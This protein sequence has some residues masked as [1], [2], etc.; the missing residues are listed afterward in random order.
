MPGSITLRPAAAESGF[1]LIEVLVV[2][3][4]LALLIA[5]LLPSLQ[6]ARD[7]ARAAVCGANMKQAV[8]GTAMTLLETGMRKERW[9]TNFG[10]ATRSLKVNAQQAG[11]FA[12]PSDPD[13]KPIPAV[14]AKLYGGDSYRG[15]T[16]SDA[17]FNHVFRLD[18]G[19]WQTDIQDSVDGDMF[20]GDA[21][22][23][24]DLLLEYNA[25]VRMQTSADVRI[26]EKEA[27]WRFDVLTYKE[28]TLWPDAQPG[29]GPVSLPL[30]WMSYGVNASAGMKN[31]SGY[32]ALIVESGK[33]GVFPENLTKRGYST[34]TYPAD[35][36]GRVLRFR[37]GPRSGVKVLTGYDYNRK[38]LVG[39]GPD[40]R[41]EPRQKMNAGYLDGHVE[42]LDY[43]QMLDP[44]TVPMPA[45]NHRV[46]YGTRRGGAA[47]F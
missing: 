37:H 40:K 10:W 31:V 6:Q 23:D 18:G 30:L 29:N 21:F 25:P 47:E 28:R 43:R 27:A 11:I 35:H 4:V 3:A 1:T 34:P 36:L 32:P 33:L 2:T 24:I 19:L 17:I 12:C 41:Y 13:P 39:F 7:Q 16:S 15:T 5:I 22:D 42:R 44:Q 45:P 8:G 26:Q 9:S 20:G 46:W 14:L 38:G